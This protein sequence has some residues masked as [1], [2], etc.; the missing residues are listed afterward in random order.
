MCFL[1][2]EQWKALAQFSR[3]G[4]CA[5]PRK[6]FDEIAQIAAVDFVL[7]ARNGVAIRR[8][9]VAKPLDHLAILLQ[10]LG[11]RLPAALSFTAV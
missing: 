5:K 8:R 1:A 11:L 7:P 3:A 6:V 4:L 10:R 2:Y 9:R